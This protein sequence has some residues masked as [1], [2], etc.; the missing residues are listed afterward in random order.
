MSNICKNKRNDRVI[1]KRNEKV[2]EVCKEYFKSVMNKSMRGRAEMTST[3][4]DAQ[5][6]HSLGKVERCEIEEAVKK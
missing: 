6:P 1:E 5:W 2:K 4:V 3:S